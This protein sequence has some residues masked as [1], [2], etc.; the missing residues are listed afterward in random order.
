MSYL[1]GSISTADICADTATRV[2]ERILTQVP[3]CSLLQCPL[4]C[5]SADD[6]TSSSVASLGATKL[7]SDEFYR[8]CLAFLAGVLFWLVL[9]L[10]LLTRL[11]W[12]RIVVYIEL[13]LQP[14][15]VIP[16][17]GAPVPYTRGPRNQVSS[18]TEIPIN[19]RR[20]SILA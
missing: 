9:D 1:V 3:S 8:L 16:Q 13:L 18:D 19:I 4:V 15:R 14:L 20:P 10:V 7:S 5:D 17:R 12:R 11:L 6:S 2:A